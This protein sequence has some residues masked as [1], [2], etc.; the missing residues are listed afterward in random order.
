M[1]KDIIVNLGLGSRDPA[2]DYALSVADAFGA[3]LLGT[4]FVYEPLIPSVVTGS[5]PAEVIDS[6]RRDTEASANR[7]VAR[8]AEAAR[9]VGVSAETRI[10]NASIAGAADTFGG[11]ARRFDLVVVGQPEPEKP[12]PEDILVEGALFGGG[13][14]V[15]IVPF[16]QKGGLKLDHV[17]VCWDGSRTAARA[18]ADAMPLLHK[19]TEVEVLIVANERGKSDELPGADIAQHLARHGVKVDVKRISAGDVDVANIVLSHA[20]DAGAD[21]IVMGGYGHS[22]LREFVLGGVTR[23][24]LQSMTVP[25]LMSH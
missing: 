22:R 13:R 4:A 5:I 11:M 21:F 14:P 20:A 2:S 10:L 16:I 6:Q 23:G 8:F 17:L 3:H 1:I 18:L 12:V 9:R 19:A 24:I 7:G 25:T 15:I